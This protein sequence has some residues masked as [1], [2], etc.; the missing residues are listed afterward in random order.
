M[1]ENIHRYIGTHFGKDCLSLTRDL[2]K[3]S[4]KL[5]DYRNHLRFNLK[6]LHTDITPRSLWIK[7]LVRGYRAERIIHKA[8]KGLIN[9]RIRQTNFT[10]NVLKGQ[11]EDISKKLNRLLPSDIYEQVQEFTTRGQLDQHRKV[12]ERQQNKY[13]R[14][15]SRKDSRADRDKNWRN[16]DGLDQ[17]GTVKDRWVKN[18]SS[19]VL[20]TAE[21]DVLSRGL[22]FAVT[23]DKLPHVEIITA[24]E[25][26][27]RNNKLNSGDAEE[28]RTKVNSCLVNA[29]LPRSN[30]S[31]EQREA[32]V[33]LNQDPDILVLPADKG[34]CTVVIDKSDYVN[35]AN[36][37][38][39]DTKVYQPLKRDPTSGYK[40]KVSDSLK[41]LEESEA[42][43]RTLYYKLSPADSVPRFYG[44]PKIHKQN[45]PLRPIVSCISSVT[46]NLARHLA[47]IIGPLV[48]KSCHH[49]VNSTDLVDKLKDIKVESDETITSYDVSALFTSVPPEG[50]IDA[51]KE[52]LHAD[53]TLD[54]RTN[55]NV[56]QICSL[57]EL[58]LNTTY[59][60][61][62]GSITN[63]IMDAR[64]GHPFLQSS[65]TCTWNAS[66]NLR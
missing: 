17:D 6:C 22:N 5:A 65:R 16:N 24:T 38:L 4:R 19:R 54:Q 51:V 14:L 45:V 48:G 53:S 34:R 20:S 29:K 7:P 41:A 18:L 40:K 39:S 50:A 25:S 1:I 57:L 30:I 11:I 31:T 55:L 28:L 10:I 49:V 66:N 59:F 44:L 43:D 47:G 9:E 60:V 58:C 21:K 63:K 12:K 56:D 64:W 32:I 15:N 62:E 35:K 37:L 61:Y 36:D 23:P 33:A 3:T 13:S 46:Y 52:A 2:E 42:I 26:A 8:Q 27:I